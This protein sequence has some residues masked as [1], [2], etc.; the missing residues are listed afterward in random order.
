M[1][2]RKDPALQKLIVLR[3]KVAA[4]N[5]PASRMRELEKRWEIDTA[6]ESSRL[7][8]SHVT[9]ARFEKLAEA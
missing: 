9:R 3:H 5:P 7:E 1:Y 6:Y 2:M 8:G 4:N